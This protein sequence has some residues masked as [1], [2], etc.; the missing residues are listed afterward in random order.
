MTWNVIAAPNMDRRYGLPALPDE[1]I[2]SIVTDPPYFLAN[3]AGKG[4]MGK[5][6]D[7][8]SVKSAVV[9]AHLRQMQLA[10]ST[11]AA[12]SAAESASTSF[13]LSQKKKNSPAQ[14]AAKKSSAQKARSNPSTCSAQESVI[15]RDEAL[16]LCGVLL[17]NHISVLQKLPTSARF[18]LSPL[19]RECGSK[20]IVRLIAGI[21]CEE[22][23]W[24]ESAIRFTS[25]ETVTENAIV[26]PDG[27]SSESKSISATTGPV[28]SAGN[29]APTTDLSVITSSPT[30]F[31][32]IIQRVISLLFVSDAIQRFTKSPS[33]I[34]ILSEVFHLKWARECLR[35]LKPGGHMLAFGGSRTVHRMTSAIEDAGFEIRD[36]IIW[37]HGQGFPKNLNVGKAIDKQLGKKREIV[38]KNPNH[39]ADSGMNYEGVY[40]GGNTG[41]A[42]IT[43][44]ASAEAKRWDGWGTALKPSHEPIVLARK[45]FRST[46]AANILKHGTGALNID[47][48]RV[49]EDGATKRSGQTPYP[50]TAEG[51]E[52]RSESWARTGHDVEQVEG[53]RWPANLIL[54]H[55]PDC[56]PVGK[57]RLRGDRREGSQGSRPAGFVDTGAEAGDSKPSGPLYGDESVVLWNCAV[58][59]PVADLERQ[60]GSVEFI[61]GPVEGGASRFF[62]TFRYEAKPSR[63]EKDAGLAGFEAS[64]GG[65]ATDRKDGSKGLDNPRA[66]AGRTGGAKNT[67]ATVKSIELM[68]W[69]VTLITPPNG[70]VLDP[71]CGSGSTGCACVVEGFDF[72]GLELDEK[73]AEIARARIE[74][75]EK[76][77]AEQMPLLKAAGV[78]KKVRFEQLDMIERL[79]Q[80]AASRLART[81]D[82]AWDRA[83][84]LA[85]SEIAA[86][87]QS[88]D[89][90]GEGATNG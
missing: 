30:Q 86:E 35:V 34:P 83:I 58:G 29:T 11:G 19:S 6:W 54:S 44:P 9:E 61:G 42:N 22:P 15:T 70:I 69:L 50:K 59:C 75:W 53:G 41:A 76:W 82:G 1:C 14:P 36:S 63:I 27:T 43:A 39:R 31:H 45:P 17:P 7:S 72:L 24:L 13:S 38:G 21:L 60:S 16:V 85:R 88:T 87:T 32:K 49:G 28:E 18:V 80:A 73:Y 62:T 10:L 56:E 90:D 40:A 66:G 8:Q 23:A 71:F 37:I 84:A 5:E 74:F 33:S 2:D 12:S 3:S 64:T 52:D 68:K 48:C 81:D 4:F 47:G 89:G 79:Q 25:T 57:G 51:G 78:D 67:H 26:D 65:E 20:S 46:V 77:E 55:G